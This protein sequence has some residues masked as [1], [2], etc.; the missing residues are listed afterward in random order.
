MIE[1]YWIA[2]TSSAAAVFAAIMMRH[3][4]V[5]K[6]DCEACRNACEKNRE[7]HE[8]IATDKIDVL[9]KGA[10]ENIKLWS[11]LRD[12]ISELKVAIVALKV[13]IELQTPKKIH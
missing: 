6:K 8:G 10:Q 7:Y 5:F 13:T 1:K 4:L 12:E 3:L 11:D 2:I 9:T